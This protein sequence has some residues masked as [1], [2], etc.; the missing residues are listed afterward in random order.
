MLRPSATPSAEVVLLCCAVVS[1]ADALQ[2]VC[3][4]PRSTA[5]P[6]VL[7]LSAAAQ[8]ALLSLRSSSSGV[9]SKTLQALSRLLQRMR[10]GVALAL[11]AAGKQSLEDAAPSSSEASP[12]APALAAA[13]AA[14]AADNSGRAAGEGGSAGGR[15]SVPAAERQAQVPAVV[16]AEAWLQDLSSRLVLSVY[17][18]APYYRSFMALQLLNLLLDE[19]GDCLDPGL[20]SRVGVCLATP[21]FGPGH[22]ALPRWQSSVVWGWEAPLALCLRGS[23]FP[24]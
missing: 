7:E 16:A 24:F 22:A 23:C 9:R 11:S 15:S 19:W 21:G 18:G 3:C 6:S 8:L 4:H 13:A 10:G 1:R 5:L 20:V 2:L 17:P 14:A 12:A